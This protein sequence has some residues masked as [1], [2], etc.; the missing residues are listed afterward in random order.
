MLAGRPVVI[1]WVLA[2]HQIV[3]MPSN[4]V[5]PN[6]ILSRDLAVLIGVLAVLE[7]ELMADE[8]PEHLTGRLRDRFAQEDLLDDAGSSRAL[9]QALNDLNHR[10]RYGLGEYPEMPPSVPTPD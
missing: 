10:L 2:E 7:G 6:P 4:D 9:R 8:M 1:A 3:T 5:A